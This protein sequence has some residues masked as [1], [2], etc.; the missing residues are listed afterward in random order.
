MSKP[1]EAIAHFTPEGHDILR[2]SE[3]LQTIAERFWEVERP[4]QYIGGIF[5]GVGKYSSVSRVEDVALKVSSPTSSESANESG[6]PRMP[7][8]L[9]SQ[10]RFLSAL[11]AHLE[12]GDSNIIVPRQF[13][14]MHSTHNGYLLG[15]Q[16]M[17]G[18]EPYGDNSYELYEDDPAAFKQLNAH[19]KARIERAVAGTALRAGL[20]DLRLDDKNIHVDNILVPEDVKPSK[21]MPLCILDQPGLTR[22]QRQAHK[23]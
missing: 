5:V 9:F 13:F 11:G 20:N 4:E 14:V 10:F 18:W 15:Q 7:E 17:E 3:H 2:R 6:E 16:F 21:D 19:L 1:I 23:K 12:Q 22:A 8:N